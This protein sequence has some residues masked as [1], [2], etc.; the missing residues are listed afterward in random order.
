MDLISFD[1][2]LRAHYNSRG[3]YGVWSKNYR[4]IQSLELHERQRLKRTLLKRFGP[5]RKKMLER[6]F[7]QKDSLLSHAPAPLFFKMVIPVPFRG[8]G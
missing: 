3:E 4:R 7:S 5:D 1:A 8:D 6:Q 2:A